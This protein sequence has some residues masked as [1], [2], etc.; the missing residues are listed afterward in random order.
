MGGNLYDSSN[1][2]PKGLFYNQ[3]QSDETP[4]NSSV[5]SNI[6]SFGSRIAATITPPS[7]LTPGVL[8]NGSARDTQ[9]ALA[10]EEWKDYISRFFPLEDKLIDQYDNA[11]MRET[12]LGE[13]AR[14]VNQA[15]DADRGIQQRRLSR[16]GVSLAPDQQAALDRQNQVARVA[17]LTDVRNLTRDAFTDLDSQILTGSSASTAQIGATEDK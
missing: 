16:Y 8:I 10:R 4:I 1:P 17:T 15:F 3:T 11:A 5:N 2:R 9:A 13:N 12:A 6:G 14:A 7:T